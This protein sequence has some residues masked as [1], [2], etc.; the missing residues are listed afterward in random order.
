L[1]QKWSAELNDGGLDF[2]DATKLTFA[3]LADKYEAAKLI[4]AEHRG[5]E[6]K[7]V[8]V[9]GRRSTEGPKR[10][11]KTLREHFGNWPIQNVTHADIESFKNERLD[12][13]FSSPRNRERSPRIAQTG[14]RSHFS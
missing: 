4:S 7:K 14:F 3:D 2:L 12:S 13:P 11:L 1:R 6:D 5:P 8:K 10:W 9:K